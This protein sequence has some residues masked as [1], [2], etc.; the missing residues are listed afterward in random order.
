MDGNLFREAP[1]QSGL[2]RFAAP[3]PRQLRN[4]DSRGSVGRPRW[5]TTTALD[6]VTG[7]INWPA[8]LMPDKFLANRDVL[9][10]MFADRALANGAIGPQTHSEITGSINQMREILKSYISIYTPNQY[11]ESRNFLNS[12]AHEASLPASALTA[13]R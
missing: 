4:L 9:D 7:A 3:A 12:L 10:H 6:P 5:L 13:S 1:H 11:I 8:G 2:S